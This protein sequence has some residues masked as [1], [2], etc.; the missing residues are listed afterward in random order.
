MKKKPP[1]PR[2]APTQSL[3]T[4]CLQDVVFFKSRDIKEVEEEELSQVPVSLDS[5]SLKKSHISDNSQNVCYDV[6][7][8]TAEASN[9]LNVR[10]RYI[11]NLDDCLRLL[12]ALS[13][14]LA[15]NYKPLGGCLSG[16]TINIL[17][18]SIATVGLITGNYWL[19]IAVV[20]PMLKLLLEVGHKM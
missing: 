20:L 5:L 4:D 2:S 14:F 10:S 18:L 6:S 13:D 1:P 9:H 3:R 16:C 17:S 8:R 12:K 19:L 15:D 11:R 7:D